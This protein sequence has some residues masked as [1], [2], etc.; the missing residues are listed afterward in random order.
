MGTYQLAQ[1]STISVHRKFGLTTTAVR[2]SVLLIGLNVLMRLPHDVATIVLYRRQRMMHSLVQ[3]QLPVDTVDASKVAWY[4][5]R[6]R[7]RELLLSKRHDSWAG[8]FEA[9]RG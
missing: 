1:W 9:N 2:L 6:R 3:L 4:A 5:Q 8:V 7:H